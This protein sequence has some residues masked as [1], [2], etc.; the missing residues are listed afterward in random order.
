MKGE[1]YATRNIALTILGEL[2]RSLQ[3]LNEAPKSASNE[4][5]K[6]SLIGHTLRRIKESYEQIISSLK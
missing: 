5:A 6:L 3:Q 4:D 2:K 1:F